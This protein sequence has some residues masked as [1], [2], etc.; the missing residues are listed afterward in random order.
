MATG[1]RVYTHAHDVILDACTQFKC[2]RHGKIVGKTA[3]AVT[4]KTKTEGV[5]EER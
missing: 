3:H 2:T 4:F 5:Q 1:L